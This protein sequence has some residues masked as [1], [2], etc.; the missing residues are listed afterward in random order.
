MGRESETLVPERPILV[1]DDEADIRLNLTAVLRLNGFTNAVGCA[2]TGEMFRALD[3]RGSDLVLLDLS[4]PTPSGQEVLPRLRERYPEV[5]V[6]IITGQNDAESA[7]ACMKLGVYDYLVKAIDETKL[8][9]TIRRALEAAALERENRALKARLMDGRLR[10]PRAF[11]DI[12]WADEVIRSVLLYVDSVAPSSQ[13]VLITGETGTGKDLIAQAIHRASGRNGGFIVVNAS[14]LD[15]TMLSDTLFGHVEGAYTDAKG[16]RE[17]LV[18]QA[19]GGTLFLD[20]IGD[21]P[22]GSQ[23]K[24]LRLLENREYYQLGGDYP[25]HSDAR[26]IVATNRVLEEEIERG[27]FRKDL[28]Y[29]LR[30]HRVH[31]PPL[32]ERPRDIP[33]LARHFIEAAAAEYRTDVPELSEDALSYLMRSELPGNVRELRALIYDA[34]SQCRGAVLEARNLSGVT[35]SVPVGASAPGRAPGAAAAS[36]RPSDTETADSHAV[37][38]EELRGWIQVNGGFPTL[39]DARQQLIDLA[40]HRTGGNQRRAARLLG[41]SS[42]ALSKELKKRRT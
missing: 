22:A 18:A 9:T 29:R 7:V 34:V 31:I 23:V 3:E 37:A 39:R 42:A 8:I 19:A 40:L 14:G 11:A 13:T 5:P 24:L 35:P 21:L 12:V 30:T 36:E 28:Y 6:V 1:V 32:R 27:L 15:E 10:N 2:T 25:L 17:G 33:A 16:R 4:M 20:E 41:I 26:V 38:A